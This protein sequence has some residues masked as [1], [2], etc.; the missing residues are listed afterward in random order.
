V[1]LDSKKVVQLPE[2]DLSLAKLYKI[3]KNIQKLQNWF[4]FFEVASDSSEIAL[5]CTKLLRNLLK[6][7]QVHK[8]C[9]E[10]CDVDTNPL[11]Y[12]QFLKLPSKPSRIPSKSFELL[13]V[14]QN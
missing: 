13:Q 9:F 6:L 7:L 3:C 11:K 5:R 1:T 10:F 4:K 12:L 2:D 8:N 14:L